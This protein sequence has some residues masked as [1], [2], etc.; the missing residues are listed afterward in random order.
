VIGRSSNALALAQSADGAGRPRVAS[1]TKLEDAQ[2]AE[3]VLRPPFAPMRLRPRRRRVNLSYTTIR[4]PITGRSGSVTLKRGNV[5]SRTTPRQTP[6]RSSRSRSCAQIYVGFNDSGA[7]PADVRAALADSERLPAVVTIAQSAGQADHRHAHL[8]R[9]PG[10]RGDPARFPSRQPLPTT[11][12][13]VAWPVRQ[14]QPH[15]R[16]QTNAVVVP[17]PTIQNRPERPL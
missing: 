16:I 15:A 4:S 3:K 2:M 12:P 13:A 10:R 11:H 9:Q 1:A 8:R 14:R 17:S 7:A 5:V 6:C